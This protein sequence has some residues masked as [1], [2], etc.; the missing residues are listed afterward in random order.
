[1]SKIL[2]ILK[3]DFEKIDSIK[4]LTK[5]KLTASDYEVLAIVL[6]ELATKKES[7][8]IQKN[9]ANYLTRFKVNVKLGAVNYTAKI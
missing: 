9:I 1:M 6:N 5:R 2:R 4:D 7:N 3:E 8:F